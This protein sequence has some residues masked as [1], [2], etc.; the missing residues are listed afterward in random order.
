[1]T[2]LHTKIIELRNQDLSYSE[3]AKVIPCSL[4]TVKYYL[5]PRRKEKEKLK[6]RKYRAN[7]PIIR[8][9]DS[10][11]Q[12]SKR[13]LDN[14]IA[15]FQRFEKNEKITIKEVVEKFKV[16]GEKCYLTGKPI[17]LSKPETYV[18][19]HIIPRAQGGKNTL[20]NLG[21]CRSDINFCKSDKTPEEFFALCKEVLEYQGYKISLTIQDPGPVDFQI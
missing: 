21:F 9:L 11:T 16:L 15:H 18:F 3:I 13:G 17:D 20:N 1:M 2:E 10:F 12:K 19:D 7:N 6:T 4:S 5:I 8:K 14:K